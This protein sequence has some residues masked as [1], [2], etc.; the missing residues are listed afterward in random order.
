MDK[1]T[2][3]QPAQPS[4]QLSAQLAAQLSDFPLKS[5]EKLRYADTDRQGHVNNAVFSTMLETGRVEFLHP[6]GGSWHDADCTFVIANLNLA[7]RG[8]IHWPGQVDIGTRVATI[9]KSS[10][11]LEQ[12]LFQN[13]QCVATAQTVIV[14][15]N[16][17]TRRSQPFSAAALE[18]L[19]Q[20]TATPG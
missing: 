5:Y 11:T 10:L 19:A 3:P 7:F 18:R 14:Q 20:L 8:E 16:Q 13:N 9:G 17:Q 6:A 2:P 4:A 1:A 15:M 12:A